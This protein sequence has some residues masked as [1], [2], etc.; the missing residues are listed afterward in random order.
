MPFLTILKSVK[1][2][3]NETVSTIF[4]ITH[5]LFKAFFYWKLG[6]IMVL[7]Q[8]WGHLCCGVIFYTLCIDTSQKLEHCGTKLR[9][10]VALNR[11]ILTVR[12]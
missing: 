7:H 3:I 5:H 11:C 10:T 12:C 4:T 6:H 9:E 8:S 1:T 2:I